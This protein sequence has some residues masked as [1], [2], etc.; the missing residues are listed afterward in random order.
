MRCQQSM[1]LQCDKCHKNGEDKSIIGKLMC[2]GFR[3]CQNTFI[4]RSKCLDSAVDRQIS[5]KEPNLFSNLKLWPPK[6]VPQAKG[7]CIIW[8][9]IKNAKSQAHPRITES[10]SES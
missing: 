2:P 1:I 5:S 9:F 6:Y 4:Y 7:F 8:E 10:E 3:F